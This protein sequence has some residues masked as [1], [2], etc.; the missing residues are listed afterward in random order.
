LLRTAA[1]SAVGAGISVLL[2]SL[3]DLSGQSSLISAAAAGGASLIAAA[4]AAP[5]VI[6]E[7]KALLR[8]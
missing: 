6:P 1:A 4:G 7:I 2:L 3:V 5:F 8:V